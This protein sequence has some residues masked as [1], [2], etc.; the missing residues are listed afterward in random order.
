M[1]RRVLQAF[2][3][4]FDPLNIGYVAGSNPVSTLTGQRMVDTHRQHV[5]AWDARPYP[6]F[7]NSGEIWRDADNWRLGH[8]INGRTAS[9]PL[10]GLVASLLRDY[11]F[12]AFDASRLTGTAAGLVLDRIMS[13]R[14]ALQ[15]LEL[16]FFID[17]LESEGQIIFRPRG[18][19]NQPIPLSASD[20]VETTPDKPLIRLTRAQEADL[21]VSAKIS[22][23]AATSD[24]PQAVAEA[25]RI[26]GSSGRVSSAALGLVLDPSDAVGI[27]E[28]WLFEA[29]AARERAT[30]TLPPSRLAVEPSDTI[31][32]NTGDRHY[33]LR[34]TDIG[35][36]GARDI[37]ARTF[38]SDIYR[39]GTAPTR[40]PTPT[41]PTTAGAPL[42]IFLDL[43][44]GPGA[45]AASGLVAAAQDPWPGTLA[46][47]RSPEQSGF[48]LSS[49]AAS[50]AVTGLTS[51]A[52]QPGPS[53]RMDYAATI[54]VVLDRGTLQSVTTLALLGGA[55]TAAIER[56]PDVWEVFQFQSATL[57]APL[58][59]RLT[60]L[61]RGQRGTDGILASPAPTNARFVLL[62]DAVTTVPI[63]PDEI[64]LP[65]N[66][67]TGPASRDIGNASYSHDTQR[68]SGHGL[69]P[70]A[71]AHIRGQR[72]PSGDLS[73][74]WVR[75]TRV[76]GDS[77]DT[78]EVPLGETLELY[79]VGIVSGAAVLRTLAVSTP[80][81]I[82]TSTDQI[83]DFGSLPQ[84]VTIRIAQVSATAGR[85]H[86]RTIN[87]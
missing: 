27:S 70:F 68:F 29:W 7:P 3:Q 20:L 40:D 60:G 38:D 17:S 24:Y 5:Y 8:W 47:Y 44:P 61:L 45:D 65:L 75:R 71:P 81:A 10:P 49:L 36:H 69:K 48:T 39:P 4:A 63:S 34:I 13:A 73:L 72:N 11:D 30:F 84:H 82:Y 83:A 55:N 53:S 51:T 58:T 62:D 54:T 78:I 23:I 19:A 59:Y 32:L 50:P 35:D 16:A 67:R 77:W 26:A 14:E 66:W 9:A 64:N 1:Q 31:D 2:I 52:V 86:T 74:T 56:A 41:Q 57:T 12:A 43:P 21:P 28:S 22:Y 42:V 6:A 15:P 80:K 46:I 25:R 87:V 85:G 33:I 76:N 18:S 79:E 37:E